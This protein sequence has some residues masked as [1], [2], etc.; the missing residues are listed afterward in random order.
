EDSE[1]DDGPA[2]AA[3]DGSS[4]KLPRCSSIRGAQAGAGGGGGGGRRQGRVSP[5][6]SPR[7][8]PKRVG[9]SGNGGVTTPVSGTGRRG[10]SAK[11]PM[12]E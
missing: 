6:P 12:G 1:T 9:G 5:G 2:D 7:L 10:C 8:A 11:N 3:T 4:R